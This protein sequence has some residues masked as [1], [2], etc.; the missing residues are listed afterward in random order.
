MRNTP[1]C[2]GRTTAEDLTLK[3]DDWNTPT[4]VGRTCPA[5]C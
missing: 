4:C 2:V 1:T 5:G 3:I